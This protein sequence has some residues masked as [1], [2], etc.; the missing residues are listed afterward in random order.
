V[1]KP[2]DCC[3]QRSCAPFFVA[4]VE[5]L[6]P[7]CSCEVRLQSSPLECGLP[8]LEGGATLTLGKSP[9]KTLFDN[10]L[11]RCMFPL[12]QL[13]HFSIKSI[14]YLYGRLHMVNHII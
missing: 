8:K 4:H 12:G 3:P 2:E 7:G 14:W 9:A 6:I 11:H 1:R 13:L 10:S 5:N